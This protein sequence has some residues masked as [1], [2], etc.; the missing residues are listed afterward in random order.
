MRDKDWRDEMPPKEY[1]C[2]PE[3][4]RISRPSQDSRM[5]DFRGR[6]LVILW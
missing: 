5:S 4:H 1:E 6:E 2:Y 3:Q